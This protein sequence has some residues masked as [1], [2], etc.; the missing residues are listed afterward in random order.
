MNFKPHHIAFTVDDIVESTKWYSE[1]LGFQ[2]V[3]N[4]ER[5]GMQI[6]LLKQGDFKIE[7]FH[8]PD[9]TSPLPEADKN[10]MKNLHTIGTKHICL[11]VDDLDTTIIELKE[12]RVEFATEIDTAGFG[13]R[14]VFIKDCNDILIEIYQS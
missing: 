6:A 1:K 2:T 12:K 10:L 14:Y 13:G 9:N 5:N 8:F 3:H 11:E 7:L 4:Y